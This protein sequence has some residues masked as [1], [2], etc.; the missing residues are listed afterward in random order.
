MSII[1]LDK[2]ECREKIDEKK[3]QY[4]WLFTLL[5]ASRP[6]IFIECWELCPFSIMSYNLSFLNAEKGTFKYLKG[7]TEI[8]L[9]YPKN[10]SFELLSYSD[11]DFARCLTERNALTTYVIFLN[12]F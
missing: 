1:K 6:D 4:D 9:W 11:V 5:I 10:K 12:I 3:Y 7:T 8:E 2:D